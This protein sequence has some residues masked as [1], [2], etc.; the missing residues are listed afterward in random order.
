MSVLETT[1]ASR[2]RASILEQLEAAGIEASGDAGAFYPQPVGVLVG[3]PA[4]AG[5]GLASSTYSVPVLV[6]SGDPLNSLTA[7]DRIYALA[8]DV[9]AVL[10]TD[11]YR[12]SQWR[13]SANAEP[14][15]AIELEVTITITVFP[16]REE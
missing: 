2:A 16:P 7:V 9:A 15:P 13:S 14:L 8:D 4:L 3:L 6:V 1:L 5:R 11:T 12:P 10:R